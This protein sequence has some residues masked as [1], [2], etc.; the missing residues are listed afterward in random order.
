MVRERGLSP[1]GRRVQPLAG[2]AAREET[3]GRRRTAL[4]HTADSNHKKWS[5]SELRAF[6]GEEIFAG[7]RPG[8]QIVNHDC[9]E[10]SGLEHLGETPSGCVVEH[11]RRF[12]E[13]DLMIY[14]GQVM[15]YTW[16]GYTGTGAVIGMASTRSILSHH[17]H[18]VVNH[19]HT[20]TGDHRRMYFRKLKAEISA[21]IEQATGKRIFYINWVGGSGGR[22]ARIFAGYSPEVEP[23]AWEAADRFSLVEVPQADILVIGLSERFAYGS[24]DNPLVAA[25]G[26][27]YPPRVWLGDHVLRRGGVVIGMTPSSGEIDAG[28]Y[29]SYREVID[30]YARHHE[31]RELAGHQDAI[32]SRPDYLERLREGRRLPP[33]PPLL[34]AVCVRLR[35]EPGGRG[36]HGRCP[37]PRRVQKARHAPGAIVRGRL[38]AGRIDRRPE[39]GDGGRTD[40]LEQAHLQV[41]GPGPGGVRGRLTTDL[42][43]DASGIV[44]GHPPSDE[45]AEP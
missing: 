34:A 41:R 37:Q 18:G 25:I 43:L 14:V 31:I 16:G 32:A 7:F 4:Q 35:P 15:A 27:G 23:P 20:A 10:E 26:V 9:L 12:V 1:A 29:L 6:V 17:N 42:A 5:E 45:N 22:M 36:V 38:E 33:H 44:A 2:R 13:A 39:P 24:A 40:I 21:H 8:G 19:P 11:N 3:R 30:L 28:T